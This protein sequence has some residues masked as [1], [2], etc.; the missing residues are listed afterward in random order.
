MTVLMLLSR[1]CLETR[2]FKSNSGIF[3]YIWLFGGYSLLLASPF[4]S[5]CDSMSAYPR[6][7]RGI[8]CFLPLRCAQNRDRRQVILNEII[9]KN[10][11][12][13]SFCLATCK[14]VAIVSWT[15]ALCTLRIGLKVQYSS[16]F[17]TPRWQR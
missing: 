16:K 6:F 1:F 10:G 3:V 13:Y 11:A 5:S 15:E 17:W 8:R 2:T 7:Q 14:Y 9:D 4:Q 12:V